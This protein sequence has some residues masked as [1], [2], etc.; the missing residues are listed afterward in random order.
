MSTSKDA[1]GV[2][3]LQT[4]HEILTRYLFIN[5]FARLDLPNG[6]VT[7]LLLYSHLVYRLDIVPKYTIKPAILLVIRKGLNQ[8]TMPASGVRDILGVR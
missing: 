3:P 5:N 8:R 6:M 1:C 7:V 4:F 2:H